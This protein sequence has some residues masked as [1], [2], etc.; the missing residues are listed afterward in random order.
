MPTAT[1]REAA[2][3]GT[4]VRERVKQAAAKELATKASVAPDVSIR[5]V[6]VSA[7]TQSWDPV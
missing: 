3:Q 1:T 7:I 4:L 6:G 5:V 2:A